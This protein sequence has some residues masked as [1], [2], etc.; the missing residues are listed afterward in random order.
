MTHVSHPPQRLGVV[1]LGTIGKALARALN[2]GQLPGF[3]LEAVTARDASAAAQWMG[4]HLS[5]PVDCVDFQALAERCDWVVECAPSKLLRAIGEPALRRGRRLVVL[6]A[7]ALL[8]APELIELA[9]A[10]GG[11]I[12]V[13]SGALLG[14]D[15]VSAA[16]EGTIHSVTLVTRKPVAGLLGAP[17]LVEQG[18]DITGLKEPMRLYA[19]DARGAVRGFP[20]NVNVSVALSLAGIGPER[21]QVEVWADPTVTRNT[22]SIRVDADSASFSMTIENVPSENPKTGR[23]TALSLIACLR[24]MHAPLRVGT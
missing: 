2:A 9:R 6:S 13:P 8:D 17:L 20:A 10:H 22:H 16:R 24:K 3:E 11:Q 15:A 21:T 18:L 5:S 23:I 12:I 1:G 19:G 7:G 4:E 14:L